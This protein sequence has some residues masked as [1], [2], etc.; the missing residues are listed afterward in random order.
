MLTDCHNHILP[1][2]DD[3]SKSVEMSVAMLQM[4]QKQGIARVIA[5]PHFYCHREKSV[6][7]YLE[8]RQRKIEN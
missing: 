5:T 6:A 1:E 3:G 7:S 4:M 8:R 2:M